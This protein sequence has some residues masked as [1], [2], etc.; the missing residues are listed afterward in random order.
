MTT[1]SCSK[2]AKY[3][4]A[5]S[6]P[7]GWHRLLCLRLL[8]ILRRRTHEMGSQ[9][10]CFTDAF[11]DR[12]FRR[13]IKLIWVFSWCV[14]VCY[15]LLRQVLVC[16]TYYTL[17]LPVVTSK[18]PGC[19]TKPTRPTVFTYLTTLDLSSSCTILCMYLALG[20]K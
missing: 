5:I 20:S 6:Q 12:E 10:S 18:R 14:T 8:R 16:T 9:T 11:E 4:C 19:S 15:C 2:S 3:L 1:R 17:I 13:K 7:F